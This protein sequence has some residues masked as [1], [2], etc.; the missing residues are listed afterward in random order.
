MVVKNSVTKYNS[1]ERISYLFLIFNFER[2]VSWR[3]MLF[4]VVY[5]LFVSSPTKFMELRVKNNEANYLLVR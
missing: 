3:G 5:L 2:R 4:C 1:R